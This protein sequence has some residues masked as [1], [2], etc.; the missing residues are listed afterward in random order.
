L[1]PIVCGP[2]YIDRIELYAELDR[3]HSEYVFGTIIAGS[4]GG[5]NGLAIEWAQE[6]GIATEVFKAEWERFGRGP[7]ILREERI[8]AESRPDIVVA[9]YGGRGTAK[10]VRR[11]KVAGIWVVTVD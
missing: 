7:T 8:L 4:A 6:R 1:F 11:A 3:L 2:D 10:M 9:F 5:L